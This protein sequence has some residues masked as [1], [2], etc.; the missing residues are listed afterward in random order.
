[1]TS[2][3]AA[4]VP[5][6]LSVVSSSPREQEVLA[7]RLAALRVVL[8]GRADITDALHAA[9]TGSGIQPDRM[10]R[11]PYPGQ[12]DELPAL[13][14]GADLV[15]AAGDGALPVLH[16]WVNTT[17]L[18]LDVPTVHADLRGTQATVGPLVLPGEGPC[19][20]CWRM[21]A[22][23]CADDFAAAMALEEELDARRIPDGAARPVMPAE[24]P[25]Y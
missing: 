14:T 6:W 15:I 1:M 9:L 3:R 19:F 17:G 13:M 2:L 22:L 7:G 12:R 25:L 4:P 18:M 24:W 5:D 20:L 23:A 10:V 11:V 21:R 8:I 16:Q